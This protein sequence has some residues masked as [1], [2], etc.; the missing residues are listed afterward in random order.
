MDRPL[1]SLKILDFTT[2][3]PGPFGTML[4]A[5]MGAEVLR[6]EAPHL[7]DLVRVSP[8]FDGKVSAMHALLN[9]SKRSLAL[10]LKKPG[11]VEIIYKLVKTYDIVVEQFRP[12]VMDRLGIGYEA[13]REINPGLIY[14]SITGYGQT[15]PY[16]DRAGHDNNYLSLAGVMSHTG[17]K[18]SGPAAMGIQLADVGGGSFGAVTGILAAVIQRQLTGQGQTV[19][20]SMF[21]MSVAWNSLALGSYFVSG[22]NPDFERGNLNGGG[23]YDYYRTGDGRYMSVGSL[24]PKFW[25]GFCQAIG[26]PELVAQGANRHHEAQLALKAEIGKEFAKKTQAEWVEIFAKYDVCVEPVLTAAET[27]LHPQTV[28]RNLIV[29]V[30]K[31][32]GA[33]QKQVASPLKFSGSEATYSHIGVELG[34]HTREVLTETGYSASQIDQMQE[35]GLFG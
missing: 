24:E 8:P 7:S 22:E 17:R 14:C 33:T 18:D 21:D 28:A 20:V 13:L 3:L 26:R 5:D 23:Y 27:T 31:P 25:Q 6:I 1:A 10:D 4:L 9:R 30:P 34:Q 15:G 32:D 29:E 2:L 12:G 16:K 11:A 35:Q 19:D